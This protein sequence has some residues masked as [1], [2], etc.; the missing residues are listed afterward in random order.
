MV[1]CA[2]VIGDGKGIICLVKR[3][4]IDHVG[5][6]RPRMMFEPAWLVAQV[7]AFGENAFVPGTIDQVPR[8]NRLTR[9]SFQSYA[10]TIDLEISDSSFLARHCTVMDREVVQIG[11]DILAEPMILIPRA[12]SK[13]QA[14]CAIV[15]LTGTMKDI[16]KV[17]FD[18]TGGADVLG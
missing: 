16:T 15:G 2:V 3:R 10:V 8:A 5:K 13:L 6:E 14:F 12:R 11:I 18:T 9:S 7:E 4:N 1:E 17:T